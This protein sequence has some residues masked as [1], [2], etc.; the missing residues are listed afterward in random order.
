MNSRD[1]SN[2]DS[3]LSDHKTNIQCSLATLGAVLLVFLLSGCASLNG[4]GYP[5]PWRYNP[6]TGYP[7]VGG[8]NWGRF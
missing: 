1:K 4:S 7:A 8:P 6:N 2:L 3:S 5:D